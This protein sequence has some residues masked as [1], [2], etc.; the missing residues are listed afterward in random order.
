ME[1][2][3]GRCRRSLFAAER[4]I[5]GNLDLDDLDAIGS[6]SAARGV[7]QQVNENARAVPPLSLPVVRPSTM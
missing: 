2:S 7:T 4:M 1:L 3:S 5:G 6:I